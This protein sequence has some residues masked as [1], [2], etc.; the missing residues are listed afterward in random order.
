MYIMASVL[1][2]LVLSIL[3]AEGWLNWKRLKWPA[4]LTLK[5][6][7]VAEASV[8]AKL[9]LILHKQ[10]LDI[11]PAPLKVMQFSEGN[12]V[13]RLVMHGPY[14]GVVKRTLML[15]KGDKHKSIVLEALCGVKEDSLVQIYNSAQEEAKQVA[16]AVYGKRKQ[17]KTQ[18]AV[19][20]KQVAPVQPVVIEPVVV[21]PEA[22][23]QV[24]RA[25]ASESVQEPEVEG[26][27]II[28]GFIS[29]Y[30]GEIVKSGMEKH[31]TTR[32][33]HPEAY[34]TFTLTLNTAE[35]P[36][37]LTGNDLRRALSSAKVRNGDRVRVIHVKN[38]QL[39]NGFTKKS[40]QVARLF[41]R[42]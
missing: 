20:V 24:T 26:E 37:E 35:G 31:V 28:K 5:R 18:A 4:H 12:I 42:H 34:E 9:E 15:W 14:Q 23:P 10:W 19:E 25:I 40:F 2:G 13:G 27:T 1:V 32:N 16:Q 11:T 33:G 17:A 38:I 36:E 7:K 22:V 6:T 3:L 39:D 21:Q 30:V 8:P 29:Q 41:E